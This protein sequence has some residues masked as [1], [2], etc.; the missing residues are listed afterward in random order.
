MAGVFQSQLPAVRSMSE[1]AADLCQSTS[2]LPSTASADSISRS[3]SAHS[4]TL[5]TNNI[6]VECKYA[7]MLR[8]CS[9]F[10]WQRN[11]K[12]HQQKLHPIR[13][14]QK[15]WHIPLCAPSLT[16]YKSEKSEFIKSTS[17]IRMEG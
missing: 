1:I 15:N 8:D 7:A 13:F 6:K 16:P 17:L 10:T 2:S 4:L 14:C 12:Y 9:L 3:N 5:S 11:R